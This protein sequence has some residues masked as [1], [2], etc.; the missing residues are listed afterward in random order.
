MR[1][2][3]PYKLEAAEVLRQFAGGLRASNHLGNRGNDGRGAGKAAGRGEVVVEGID[4]AAAAYRGHFASA[5]SFGAT[6]SDRLNR[7]KQ[8]IVAI[9]KKSISAA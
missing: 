1:L 5:E 7:K 3:E 8:S 9:N 2:L 4:V 6:V